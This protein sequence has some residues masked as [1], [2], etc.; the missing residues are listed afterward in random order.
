MC[1]EVTSGVAC[2]IESDSN[3]KFSEREHLL[4]AVESYTKKNE[5]KITQSTDMLSYSPLF[6]SFGAFSCEVDALASSGNNTNLISGRINLD[7][8]VLSVTTRTTPSS[9][10]CSLVIRVSG[11]L[12]GSV[13]IFRSG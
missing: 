11:H 12:L 1:I 13:I 2:L 4:Y 7:E 5:N 10:G 6:F 3:Y 9:P 8:A